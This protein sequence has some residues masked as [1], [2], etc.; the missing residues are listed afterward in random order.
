MDYKDYMY[1]DLKKWGGGG[2]DLCQGEH[3]QLED[4]SV[5]IPGNTV[6]IRNRN[7]P[8]TSLELYHYTYVLDRL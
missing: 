3:R 8:D 4:T 5:G 7:L 2:R 1:E 6:E